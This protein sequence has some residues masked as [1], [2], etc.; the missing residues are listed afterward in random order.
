MEFP[1]WRCLGSPGGEL[2]SPAARPAKAVRSWYGADVLL[3]LF[4]GEH[5]Q[6]FDDVCRNQQALSLPPKLSTP[7]SCPPEVWNEIHTYICI[8]IAVLFWGRGG[9][10]GAAATERREQASVEWG[11]RRAL[12]RWLLLR[13]WRW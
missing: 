6:S 11:L 10:Q 7:K 8:Y 13:W 3:L 9:D 2:S 1:K 12:S 5:F 4:L